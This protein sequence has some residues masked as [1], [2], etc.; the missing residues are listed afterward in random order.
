MVIFLSFFMISCGDE[1]ELQKEYGVFIGESK[2]N[3]LKVKG[4]D[5]IVVDAYYLDAEMIEELH[6]NNNQVYTYI[7]LGTLENFRD[8]YPQFKDKAL[9]L[10][11][12]WPEENWMDV[13]YEP[14]QEN[15]IHRAEGYSKMGVDGFFVDNTDVYSYAQEEKI[16]MGLLDSLRKLDSIGLPVIING[17]DEFVMRGLKEDKLDNIIDGINQETVFTKINF[18][19]NTFSLNN[20]KDRAYYSNYV[21]NASQYGLSIFLLEYGSDK[22]ILSKIRQYCQEKGFR[23]YMSPTLELT[24]VE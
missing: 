23:Y 9:G 3:L 22:E 14:W 21:E 10:Y 13:S 16:Y 19:D 24:Y 20:S 15:F 5:L 2:E 12:D 6:E 18:K 11:G 1:K 7:S 4:Y 17:G 8:F